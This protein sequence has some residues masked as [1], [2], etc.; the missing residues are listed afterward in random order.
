MRAFTLLKFA[1]ILFVFSGI[2]L[3]F[4]YD[5]VFSRVA[6]VRDVRAL[7]R[8]G[9]QA[10]PVVN[11]GVAVFLAGVGFG[12]LA[13]WIGPFDLT[14]GWLIAAY[15]LVGVLAV[16]GFAVETPYFE[17]IVAEVQAGPED[18]PSEALERLLRSPRRHV[19]WVSAAL[20][21][22]IVFVMVAKPF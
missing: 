7:R 10:T 18:R 6:K 14:A 11:T 19:T 1:H 5:V 12:L 8:V 13:A 15:V 17:K 4:A 9:A 16:L 3:L 2:T 21:A 20:Y 22:A